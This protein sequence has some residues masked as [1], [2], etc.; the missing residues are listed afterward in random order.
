[1]L[2]LQF[3]PVFDIKK[4]EGRAPNMWRYREA[5]PIQHDENILS[6]QEGFTPLIP[7][8]FSGKEVLLKQDHLFPTGSYKDRGASVMI[9][10]VREWGLNK[11][12]EDSSGN[13]GSSVAAYC[14]KGD[15]DCQIYCPDSTS[16]GKLVQIEMYGAVLNKIPGTREDT[17]I[18]VLKAAE[19]TFYAS[20]I[21]NPFFFQGTKTF[22]FEVCEQ[23]GWAAPDTVVLPAGN[24]T[25]I[26]GA[27]I[28][29][30]ELAESGVI[31]KI[32]QFIAVQA[33]NCAPIYQAYVR[34]K[35][36]NSR[37][38]GEKTLAEGI[39]ISKPARGEQI[40]QVVHESQGEVIT[41]SEEEIRQS[42]L[43]LSS[44]G[45]FIEPTSAAVTA[46]IDKYIQGLNKNEVIVSVITGHG[47]KA[48]GK[49]REIQK[50]Y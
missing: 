31:E 15:I 47:L 7:L 16:S 1:M 12:V 37:F 24:G 13:A 25:L 33:E 6:F 46:G 29:F 27:A 41:V 10:K 19:K 20:H 42:L 28:G 2:N 36:L 23:L 5:L 34:K 9:S 48:S 38:Q 21:W 26:L 44:K 8:L 22:A 17:S 39:A 3:E 32:P 18:A 50:L 11:V 14:A 30:K 45:Y 40:L 43:S 49:I 35:G 4:I